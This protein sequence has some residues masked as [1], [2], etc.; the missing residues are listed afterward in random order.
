[1]TFRLPEVRV[2]IDDSPPEKIDELDFD[3]RERRENTVIH[4]RTRG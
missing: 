2:A 4:R 3:V 1:V